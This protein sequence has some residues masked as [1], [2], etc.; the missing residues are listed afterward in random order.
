MFRPRQAQK[1]TAAGPGV[2]TQ[3]PMPSAG[4]VDPRG[5]SRHRSFMLSVRG[6]APPAAG[7]STPGAFRLL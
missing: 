7:S 3:D 5:A 1:P 6:L 2:V 4:I